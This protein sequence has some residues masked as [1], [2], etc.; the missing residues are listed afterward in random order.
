MHYLINKSNICYFDSQIQQ[1]NIKQ[2]LRLP[3]FASPA[4]AAGSGL[5]TADSIKLSC[6]LLTT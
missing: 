6:L 3:T 2:A 4:E 1:F 5:P